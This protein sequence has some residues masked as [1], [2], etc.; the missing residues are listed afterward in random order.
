MTKT[1]TVKVNGDYLG[2][3]S[4][5]ESKGYKEVGQVT[6]YK[7]FKTV[8]ED[9]YEGPKGDL[10]YIVSFN[11]FNTFVY[12]VKIRSVA[13]LSDPDVVFYKDMKY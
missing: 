4:A 7:K 2:A 8:T 1:K 5:L 3:G 11:H 12:S 13:S 9:V 10:F 6:Y